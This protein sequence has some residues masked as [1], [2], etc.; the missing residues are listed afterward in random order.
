MSYPTTGKILLTAFLVFSMPTPVAAEIATLVANLRTMSGTSFQESNPKGF[1]QVG[2]RLVFLDTAETIGDEPWTTDG[3]TLGTELLV[4]SCPGLCSNALFLRLGTIGDQLFF[5]A[6]TNSNFENTR[7]LWVTDGTRLGTHALPEADYFLPEEPAVALAQDRVFFAASDPEEGP[8]LWV[9]DGTP[10]GS[11]KVRS[12]ATIAGFSFLH[13][14]VPVG[15]DL[16]FLASDQVHGRGLWKS[17]GTAAGTTLVRSLPNLSG[18]GRALPAG[19]GAFYT[20]GFPFSTHE[21]WVSDGTPAGTTRVPMPPPSRDADDAVGF[22]QIVGDRLYFSY[23]SAAEGNEL[24]VSNGTV[25]GTR[26]ISALPTN[27]GVV[28][29]SDGRWLA[30]LGGEIVFLA[31]AG[32]Q[33]LELWKTNGNPAQ[34]TRLAQICTSCFQS[35]LDFHLAQV[36]NRIYFPGRDA[37]RGFEP[38]T[39]DGTVAGTGPVAD[40]CP[41]AC[42]S[43]RSFVTLDNRVYFLAEQQQTQVELWSLGADP[44]DRVKLTEKPGLQGTFSSSEALEIG[45]LGERVIFR[46]FGEFGLPA[47]F[48]NLGTPDSTTPLAPRQLVE[49]GSEAP[50]LVAVG[51]GLVFEAFSDETCQLWRSQGTSATTVALWPPGEGGACA[52]QPSAIFPAAG[53]F[54]VFTRGVNTST[55]LWVSD[56]TAT[57]TRPV[58][59][60]TDFF[61]QA[62]AIRAAALGGDLLFSLPSANRVWRTDGTEAGTTPLDGI[63]GPV[64]P[65]LEVFER[66]GDRV[67]LYRGNGDGVGELWSTDGTV[68]GSLL[69]AELGSGVEPSRQ[70]ATSGVLGADLY[71]F[72]DA[73][74]GGLELW[75]TDGTPAGTSRVR[76]FSG[77]DEHSNLI[78]LG[79][80]LY[81]LTRRSDGSPTLWASDGSFAGTTELRLFPFS[82]SNGNSSIDQ[83]ALLGDKLYFAV[84]EDEE[85][86]ELWT[87]DG[88]EAGTLLLADLWPGRQSSSPKNLV[89]AGGRLFFSA[90]T[91]AHGRE[92]W[93]SNG[94]ADGTRLAHDLAPGAQSSNPEH[95]VAAGNRLYFTANDQARGREPWSVDLTAPAGTCPASDSGLCLQNNRFRVE[96]DWRDFQGNSGRGTPVPLTADTGYFWF[97]NPANVETIVKVLNGQPINQHFWTFYGALSNVEYTMTVT[98]AETGL[99]QRYFNPSR[100]FASVGDT[101]S[102]GP[103]GASIESFTAPNQSLFESHEP[104]IDALFERNTAGS[105]VVSSTRLCLNN[106]RFAVE[107]TWTDFQ[108]NR[109]VGMA[110]DLTSDTGYFWF[111]R[112]TNVEVVLKVLDGRP[113]NGRFW[114]FYGALSNVEYTLT[115][116]DTQTGAIKLYRN[117]LRNFGSLGD[118]QAFSDGT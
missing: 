84:G 85:G 78:A 30:E 94:T 48:S 100:Q 67:L 96:I 47:L 76:A 93:V 51:E 10:E 41:G 1:V 62:N 118:T 71:F 8:T 49:A 55:R 97:F 116:T 21:V 80:S 117:V 64:S 115:V 66:F 43:A 109:G 53:Q 28:T 39:S 106:G 59:D 52:F 77:A 110:E 22:T 6:P 75:K 37:T 18:L 60:F 38:W 54:F 108:G 57:G 90:H 83:L 95:L 99:T 3:T 23:W 101:E 44:G 69:L 103:N 17:D 82:G 87:S 20:F 63:G 42:G 26:R 113:V 31:G 14:F 13:G 104:E 36:G 107:A 92:L 79:G 81:F 35:F 40:L 45:R 72:T 74:F 7:T 32:L 12:A 34:T 16:L 111:F 65:R 25:A 61:F 114:V 27:L 15:R 4:D 102:F 89:V 2:N 19:N 24:W 98:D 56:G 70:T 88:T 33:T 68:A 105:C 73:F 91:P 58:T 29:F 11:R 9:S 46:G 112:D 5:L 86:R 50:A